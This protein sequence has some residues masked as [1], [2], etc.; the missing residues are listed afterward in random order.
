[1]TIAHHQS[2]DL[3][4]GEP[5]FRIPLSNRP[6]RNA[7]VCKEGLA[8]IEAND[9]KSVF[10]SAD[11]SRKYDYVSFY[12]PW[13][14]GEMATLARLLVGA[15]RGQR[16]RY[17]DGDR[18]NLRLSNLHVERGAAKGTTPNPR[19]LGGAA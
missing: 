12:D 11:G 3:A 1:M 4:S 7:T 18:T 6:G 5:G 16:V 15:G 10:M 19:L 2:F 8:I 13:A 9:I 14:A 17:R